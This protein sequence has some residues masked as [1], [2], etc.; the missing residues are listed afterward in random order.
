MEAGEDIAASF[1]TAIGA[2]F[3]P[4]RHFPLAASA[5]E[6]LAAGLRVTFHR[7]YAIY[8]QP[9]SDEVVIIRVLHGARDVAAIAESEGFRE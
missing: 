5:R 7:A 4:V 2:A 8:Y 3:E 6:H 9:R 1:V